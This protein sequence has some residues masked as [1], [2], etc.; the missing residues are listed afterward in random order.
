MA[1]SGRLFLIREGIQRRKAME[2]VME[3]AKVTEVDFAA[4]SKDEE[5]KLPTLRPF[6]ANIIAFEK[7]YE[8]ESEKT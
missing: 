1:Q 7:T 3:K 4:R 5:S 6:P 8:S 2:D